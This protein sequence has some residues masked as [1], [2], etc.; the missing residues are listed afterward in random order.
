MV[1]EPDPERQQLITSIED[2]L[3]PILVELSAASPRSGPG[4]PWVLPA[5]AL[6]AG[7]LVGV[8]RGFSSQLDIW[9]LLSGAGLWELPHYAISDDALYKRLLTAGRTTFQTLFDQVT[10]AL[11]QRLGPV[12]HLGRLAAF[13]SGVYALDGMTLDAVSK[14][15]P[16]LRGQPE[17]VLPGKL[18]TVFDLRAQLWHTIVFEADAHANDKRLA[19]GLLTG[20]AAGSLVVADLGYFAFEWFDDLTDQGYFWVSRLRAKTSYTVQHVFYQRDG[21]LDA[22]VWLGKYRADRAAH[23]VRLVQWTQG[24]RTWAYL[25]NVIEP[26][27]LPLADIAQLYARRWDIERMFNLVKTHLHL[28]WL[29]SSQITVV[30]HQLYAVFT[31][32]QIILGLRTE[33]ADRAAAE[34]DDVSLDLLIR[35]LPRFAQTGQDPLQV[36]VERG[37]FAKIIRPASR[38]RLHLPEVDLAEYLPAPAALLLTR[39][40]R[41]AHRDW[42]ESMAACCAP[43]RGSA[44]AGGCGDG[45]S[46]SEDRAR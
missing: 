15:L 9:R 37:R 33:I 30:I 32:A 28:H 44:A 13:A 3:K 40:P 43:T 24:Q 14:R 8:A 11:R 38:T 35:W 45:I 27:Q 20:L 21:V 7:V 19:R 23:A 17:A 1:T 31:V 26:Q 42:S 41:Y 29:W 5:V 10:A 34:V 2:F 4:R 12:N 22:L 16:S 6:W 39:T 18:A 36:I 46:Q 25:T